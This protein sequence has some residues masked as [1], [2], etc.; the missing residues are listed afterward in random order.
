MNAAN[1]W[2]GLTWCWW[3]L[4]SDGGCAAVPTELVGEWHDDARRRLYLGT[5]A[6]AK[7]LAA[8]GATE[9]PVAVAEPET[10]A[11][12]PAPPRPKRESRRVAAS[13]RNPPGNPEAVL[14]KLEADLFGEM[15]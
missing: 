2:H 11:A 6:A 1:Y 9:E 8:A 5:Y 10:C 12:P 3:R 4:Y 7:R 14:A 13:D 15:P